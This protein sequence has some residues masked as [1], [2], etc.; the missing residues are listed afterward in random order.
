MFQIY[1]NIAYGDFAG[2]VINWVMVGILFIFLFD[3]FFAISRIKKINQFGKSSE[4]KAR[5]KK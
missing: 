2:Y 1:E 5:G 4:R 3:Q